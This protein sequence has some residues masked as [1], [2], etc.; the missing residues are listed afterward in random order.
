[1]DLTSGES[2]N[3]ILIDLDRSSPTDTSSPS[4]VGMTFHSGESRSKPSPLLDLDARTL[5]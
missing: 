5:L 1:M 2:P 4:R 3:P